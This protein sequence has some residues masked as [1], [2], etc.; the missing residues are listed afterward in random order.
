MVRN[1]AAQENEQA[2]QNGLAVLKFYHQLYRRKS[3]FFNYAQT[4]E[5]L[6]CLCAI[7][8]PPIIQNQISFD[9]SNTITC[10]VK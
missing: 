8:F 9:S 7:V 3:E 6:S 10:E 1:L 4:V 2:E 5:Y